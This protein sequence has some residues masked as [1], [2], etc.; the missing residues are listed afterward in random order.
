MPVSK[1]VTIV[2]GRHEMVMLREQKP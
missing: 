2:A 1:R